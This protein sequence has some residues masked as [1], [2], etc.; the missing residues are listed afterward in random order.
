MSI[1][2]RQSRINSLLQGTQGAP[3]GRANIVRTPTSLE[4]MLAQSNAQRQSASPMSA[5][6]SPM[7]QRILAD[8]AA[9]RVAPAQA[10]MA[11]PIAAPA[12]GSFMDKLMTPQSQGMLNA[13]AAGF[14]ASGY[15]DRPVSL[16]QVLGRMGTAGMQAYTAAEDRQAKLASSLAAAQRQ[17]RLDEEKAAYDAGMLRLKA[18]EVG[19]ASGKEAFGNEKQLRG[20]FDKQ[21]KKFD[22]ALL[23]FEKVQKA[24]ME[25]TASGPTD[26]ALIFGYMK[27]IDPT[28]V[29]REGEFATAEEAGGVSEKVINLYNKVRTGQR[30]TQEVRDQFVRAARTQFQPYMQ[31]QR[32]VEKRY[33][34]LSKAYNLDPTKVVLSRIPNAGT[35]ANPY[36][37]F[38]TPADAEAA[39][40]PKGTYVMI[41]NQLFIE[42]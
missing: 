9:K 12:G 27:V 41:G 20:E 38:A 25:E 3:M 40:L 24:A 11:T 36:T 8:L 37:T 15:Q 34:N 31:T 28:S 10:G 14:E 13:A 42:D 23:G 19:G 21:A 33:A 7:T 29:V 6:Q 39:N 32:K 16:G 2:D 26:L 30:L 4:Q 5:P 17:K 18:I 22:E 1:F 35:L